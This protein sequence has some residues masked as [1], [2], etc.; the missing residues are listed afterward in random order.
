[1]IA[2]KLESWLT[3]YCQREPAHPKMPAQPPKKIE[4]H[5]SDE[6]KPRFGGSSAFVRDTNPG[7]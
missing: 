4:R 7:T 3:G 2:E 1:M 5:A 6:K